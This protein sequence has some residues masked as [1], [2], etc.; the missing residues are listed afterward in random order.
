M[1][2]RCSLVIVHPIRMSEYSTLHLGVEK[3]CVHTMSLGERRLLSLIQSIGSSGGG[4]GGS[5][6]SVRENALKVVAW[7]EVYDVIKQVPA[8]SDQT[9]THMILD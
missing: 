5:S 6:A 3:Y 7:E 1:Y 2:V 4:G 8:H 9:H